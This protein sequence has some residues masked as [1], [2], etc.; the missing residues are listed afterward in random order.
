MTDLSAYERSSTE[1]N[2][3]PTLVLKVSSSVR[4]FWLH[5]QV[6]MWPKENSLRLLVINIKA[7]FSFRYHATALSSLIQ[8]EKN[9]IRLACGSFS[10]LHHCSEYS[11]ILD[12]AV[13]LTS[14]S[15]CNTDMEPSAFST[16]QHSS[17]FHRNS[18]AYIHLLCCMNLTELSLLEA[19][20]EL[21]LLLIYLYWDRSV[22]SRINET[23][24]AT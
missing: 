15:S 24:L 3:P 6:V 21:S 19:S 13:F 10:V 8:P 18:G 11:S 5:E 20:A 17:G 23:L 2:C 16:G 14:G 1:R 12:T 4:T 22:L 7:F 9:E